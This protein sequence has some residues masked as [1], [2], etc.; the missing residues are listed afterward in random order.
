MTLNG[1]IG[2][3]AENKGVVYSTK[4]LIVP[5]ASVHST[6][7]KESCNFLNSKIYEVNKMESYYGYVYAIIDQKNNKIYIGQKKGKVE[8]SLNY[9]GS[10]KIISDIIKFRGKLLLKKIILGFCEDR[11]S[12]NESEKTCIE[13]FQSNNFIYGYNLTEGG[14]GGD[15]GLSG[16]TYE[17]FYGEEKAKKLKWQHSNVLKGRKRSKEV[18]I[19]ISKGKLGKKNYKLSQTLKERGTHKGENNYMFGKHHSEETKRKISLSKK[20]KN[21]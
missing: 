13:F 8:K 4:Y 20:G 21:V 1:Q 9:F 6:N 17:E 7:K 5:F 2:L 16:K 11:K 18:C 10:G 19:N 12:L 14:E 15:I 3:Q